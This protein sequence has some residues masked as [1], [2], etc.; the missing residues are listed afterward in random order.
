MKAASPALIAYLNSGT[1]FLMADLYTLTLNGGY[2]VRYTG[3][4]MDL[5]AAGNL[6]KSF[7]IARSKTRSTVG[8]EVDTLE[9]TVN[10][11]PGDTLNGVPWIAAARNGALD[12]ATLQLEKIFMPSW[13]DTSLGSIV[14][15]SGRV[16]DLDCVRTAATLTIKSELELLDTQLPRNFYQSGCG[17]TLFDSA[18]GLNRGA[19]AVNGAATNNSV[20]QVASALASVNDYFTLGTIVFTSGANAGVTRSVRQF[21]N[22]VFTLALP[23]LAPVQNGDTFTA[24]PGCDK[25]KATCESKFAN[26][27]HF[28]GFPFVPDPE[29]AT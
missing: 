9:V 14:L 11:G 12:G 26:V 22:G 2:T 24:Y 18:C 13:G 19:F 28:R 6:F 8:L 27:V 3:A 4:D 15:F 16:S 5:T 17:N 25:V 10:P 21:A 7:L 20:T 23:L 1:Q 29:T